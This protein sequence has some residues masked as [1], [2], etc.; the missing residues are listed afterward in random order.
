MKILLILF[1]L[2]GLSFA[3]YVPEVSSYNIYWYKLDPGQSPPAADDIVRDDTTMVFMWERGSGL[4][5]PYVTPYTGTIVNAMVVVNSPTLWTDLTAAVSRDIILDNGEYE[6]T[7]TESD[8][9][10]YESGHSE[11]IYI[12]VVKSVARIQ[13]NVRTR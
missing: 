4:E 8:N 9:T 12:D 2:F 11:P 10:N 7:V 13:I 3:Q 1:V 5:P 6:V